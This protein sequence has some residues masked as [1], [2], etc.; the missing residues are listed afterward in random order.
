MHHLTKVI[1][2]LIRIYTRREK[3][4]RMIKRRRKKRKSING[5]SFM[6]LSWKGKKKQWYTYKLIKL[7]NVVSKKNRFRGRQ[8]LIEWV[9][10]DCHARLR[11]IPSPYMY[12]SWQIIDV[13]HPFRQWTSDTL[14]H[15]TC[16]KLAAFKFHFYYI[17]WL[18]TY[19]NIL[20]FKFLWD[21]LPKRNSEMLIYTFISKSLR[22]VQ[23]ACTIYSKLSMYIY[24]LI[25]TCTL[26][27]GSQV[28]S[29]MV[30][31]LFTTK[32]YRKLYT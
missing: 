15:Q 7:I 23:Y 32:I 21:S 17:C 24:I 14:H 4:K 3:G 18:V 9:S 13:P 10:Q 20:F 19:S 1:C 11:C 30:S 31:H 27:V 6:M 26:V 12:I 22:N 5:V 25:S 16:I 29:T 28:L 2:R 8:T